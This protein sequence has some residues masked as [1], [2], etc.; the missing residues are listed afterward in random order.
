MKNVHALA[1][2]LFAF[3]ISSPAAYGQAQSGYRGYEL[4]A[5]V[6]SVSTAAK[7]EAADVKT[8][9]ARPALIQDLEWRA[10]YSPQPSTSATD[11]VEQIDF[12]FYND[13]LY[14]MVITY[15]HLK[16][17]G[18]NDADVVDGISAAYGVPLLKTSPRKGA[19]TT[20]RSDAAE[21]GM[22]LARWE[23]ADQVVIL[24]RSTSFFASSTARYWL[25]V[26][27]PRLGALARTASNEAVRLDDREAPQRE[28]AQQKKDAAAA[29]AADEKARVVN[30]A[31]FRP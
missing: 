14:Q 29:R 7:S 19:A 6:S 26:T 17:A 9:H 16:T 15:D 12:S 30:K 23:S 28:A 4:G 3:V 18:M 25:T 20:D 1:G 10:P 11:P 21:D 31:A 22:T 8:I 24:Y 5:T 13:Q 2:V 27:S